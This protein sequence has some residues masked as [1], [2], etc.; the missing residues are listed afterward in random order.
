MDLSEVD[1]NGWVVLIRFGDCA[2]SGA[3]DMKAKQDILLSMLQLSTFELKKN[4]IEE[5]YAD[6][7]FYATQFQLPEASDLLLNLGGGGIIDALGNDNDYTN[8]HFWLA[9][10]EGASVVIKLVE[11]GSNL[12]RLCHDTQYTPYEES[13]TSL[14]MYSSYAFAG[15]AHALGNTEVDLEDFINQEL[16]QNPEVHP[17]WEK[18]TLLDLFTHGY[19]P[20]LHVKSW[21]CDDCIQPVHIVRVQPYWR[22][23]LRRIRKGTYLDNHTLAPTGIDVD[24]KEEEELVTTGD[25]TSSRG[26][27]NHEPD[28]TGNVP[29]VNLDD[30]A[31]GS[32]L[33]D[34]ISE[35]SGM[36][37][38]QSDCLYG[39]HEVVCMDCWLYYKETG[40]RFS[41]GAWT[42]MLQD[43]DTDE[44]SSE[45]EFSPLHVHT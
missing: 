44:D 14:A 15:W 2:T 4:I 37:P 40:H 5:K 26:D 20:D 30:L 38:T 19:R 36:T 13:P 39:K 11:R 43:S 8:L 12:H 31:S 34:D 9:Y 16:E 21:R 1:G 42:H 10:G 29:L 6:L 32:E 33:E 17:G 27:L 28:A 3:G 25:T 7:L 41:P 24:G 35:Y 45:D 23:L 22:H 18:E